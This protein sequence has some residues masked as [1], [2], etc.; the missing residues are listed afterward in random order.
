MKIRRRDFLLSSSSFV[1]GASLAVVGSRYWLLHYTEP[2][3]QY[4]LQKKQAALEKELLPTEGKTIPVSLQGAVKTLVEAG[5]IDLKK[6]NRLYAKRGREIPA[7]IKKSFF[8]P[9]QEPLHFDTVSAPILLNILWALGLSN[10]T[11]F[12]HQSPLQGKDLPNFASTGGWTLGKEENGAAYFN[13][14]SN[15][16]LDK[17]QEQLVRNL[18]ENIYR[19]CCNNSTFFQDCNHGSAMLGLLELGASQ[20]KSAAELYAIA[21]V[22][23]TYWF[24]DVYVKMGLYFTEI[25]GKSFRDIPPTQVL[26]REFSSASGFR[27]TI[28][29]RLAEHRL[30]PRS[31]RRLQGC[32]V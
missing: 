29:R 16:V 31:G 24:P 20:G 26:S 22:A 32:S 7:W 9:S 19:P 8:M 15:I 23:N 11:T 2:G 14:V 25:E 1:I 21:L 27:S 13:Q 10:K 3:K 4:V 17:K 28:L 6:W 12:N 5:V 30:L 18:A